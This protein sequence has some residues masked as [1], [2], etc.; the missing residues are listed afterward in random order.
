M[1][2]HVFEKIA[3]LEKTELSEVK[4]DLALVDDFNKEYENALNIQE[5]AELAII[6]YNN[7]AAKII[8]SLSAAGQ[9]FLKA[10]ARFQDIENF[11]KELGVDVSGALKS[12]KETISVAIKEID[13]YTKKLTSNKISV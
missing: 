11:S 12:K 8:N 4:V 10:N 5:K 7:L 2:K 3:K 9:A 1:N 13:S 6:D